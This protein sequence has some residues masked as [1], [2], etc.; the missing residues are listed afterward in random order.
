MRRSAAEAQT[1]ADLRR[2]A[3]VATLQRALLAPE[4]SAASYVPVAR[5][6]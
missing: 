6:F 4:S 2:R 3:R 1:E 5:G